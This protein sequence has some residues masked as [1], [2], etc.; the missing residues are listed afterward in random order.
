MVENTDILLAQ[1]IH[2]PTNTKQR[3]KEITKLKLKW[4]RKI[5]TSRPTAKKTIITK[6]HIQVHNAIKKYSELVLGKAQL[7]HIQN[8]EYSF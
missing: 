8:E 5:Y 4:N 7:I 2:L 3:Y 1:E 6:P